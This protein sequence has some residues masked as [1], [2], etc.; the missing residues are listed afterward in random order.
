MKSLLIGLMLTGTAVTVNAQGYLDQD[1]VAPILNSQSASG[2]A[3]PVSWKVYDY[4]ASPKGE[5]SGPWTRL[6]KHLDSLPGGMNGYRLDI[7]EMANRVTSDKLK[8]GRKLMVPE[9]FS[10]DYRS[11]APYPVYYAAAAGLSKLFIIDKY[12]QT[13]GAYENGNLVRWG[14]VSTGRTDNLTPN[15]K[16]NFGWRAEYRESSAA[17]PGEVWEMRYLVNFEPKEGIHVH[18]YSLPI[19]TPASH[20]CVRVSM[21]DAMWNYKWADGTNGKQKGTPVWVINH[22]PAGRAAHWTIDPD[23]KVKSLVRLPDHDSPGDVVTK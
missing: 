21:A 1:K 13:F 9:S 10:S 19:S 12:T 4:T 3:E 8:T 5:K 17:P 7:V 22:N 14:L 20:G 2:R 16:F 15:G 18:Q 23:G 6:K 11:Y